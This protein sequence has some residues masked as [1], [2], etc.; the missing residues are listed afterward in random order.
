VFDS[1][2]GNTEK[3]AAD[4]AE[5]LKQ[6]QIEVACFRTTEVDLDKL[7]NYDLVAVGGPTEIH[8]ASAPMRDFLS[9]LEHVDLK[10]KYG[11]AFDTKLNSWWAG[12]ASN[13]IEHTLK[14]AGAQ[15]LMPRS[16]AFVIRPPKEE[17]KL[18]GAETGE[19][20][21][22]RKMR[23]SEEKEIKRASAVLEEG[24][25]GKFEQIGLE[26]GGA[27]V[28]TQKILQTP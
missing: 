26:L 14:S 5:G 15:I 6:S 19:T 25:E 23:K 1:R 16:S 21:E 11:F 2:Y 22:E 12:D 9:K 4:I 27:L 24:M 10:G 28:Q 8:R 7:R 20:R 3:I 18:T 17:L 13:A